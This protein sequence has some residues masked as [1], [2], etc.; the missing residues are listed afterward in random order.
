MTTKT[1]NVFSATA[2]GA[3]AVG[4]GLLALG[5]AMTGPACS[6]SMVSTPGTAGTNARGGTTGTAGTGGDGAGG[7]GGDGAGGTGGDGAGGTGGSAAGSGGTGGGGAGTGGAGG[8]TGGTG[9]GAAC[10]SPQTIAVAAAIT[11][12]VTWT[13]CNTYLLPT[14]TKVAVR[15]PAILTIEPGTTIKGAGNS[16]LVITMGAKIIA[17]GTASAPIVFTSNKAVGSRAPGDW[18]GIII[19]GKAPINVNANSTPPAATAIFEAYGAAEADGM[20]GGTD[21]DDSSGSLKYVRS[22]FGGFAYM[23]SREWNNFTFCGVGRGT[24]IENIQSHKGADDAVEFFG[25]TVNAKRLVLTQNE[26]DGLDSDNGWQGKAQFVVIQH[27]APRGTDAS[28]GYESDNHAN[29]PSYTAVPRTMPLIYNVTS[30]GKKDY[31]GA[32]SFGALFRRGTGGTYYNHIIT[33]WASGVVEVRDADTMAQIT[34]NMLFI[35]NSIFFDNMGA[36]GNWPAAMATGDI[37][38]K[39]I[40]LNTAWMNREVDPM[41]GDASSLTAPNFK[42]ATGSPALTGGAAPP[43]DGFFDMTATFVGA[44]GADDWTAGW[45]S[46]PQN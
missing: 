39:T 25:G 8:G 24:V 36:D 28:N 10:T 40:F 14:D 26:D 37:D 12:D 42:P 29:A 35:K 9:G 45:T 23:P 4:L 2:F 41:L 21:P 22:E 27:V 38:E 20:F 13:H 31:I 11:A 7:T 17:N 1:R 32:A 33:K 46:Y 44:V 18:G 19:M 34:A 43:N 16:A 15:A 6:D 30:I 3:G 5:L